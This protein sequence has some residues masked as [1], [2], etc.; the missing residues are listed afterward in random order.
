MK[1]TPATVSNPP[2]NIEFVRT[3]HIDAAWHVDGADA[4]AVYDALSM[5][6]PDGERFFIE[7]VKHYRAR[8][9]GKLASDVRDFI[10][11]E[12][13]HTREHA[14][15]N[16][17]AGMS[18]ELSARVSA[19]IQ[20][21]IADA[22]A[23]GPAAML[24]ATISLEHMTAVFADCVLRDPSLMHSRRDEVTRLWVWHA[25]EEAEHKGVAFDLFQCVGEKWG[26][27]K[28][29]QARVVSMVL[30][31]H[32]FLSNWARVSLWLMEARGVTGWD[33]R[34]RILK[35]WFGRRG[36]VRR[37]IGGYLSWFRPG[38]HPW[39]HDNHALI[40]KWRGAFPTAAA[41]ESPVDAAEAA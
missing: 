41:P 16:A 5:L 29:Y 27:W 22:R 12:A 3:A 39:D 9:T 18:P 19:L 38:F 20:A 2:R 23:Q 28:R 37:S 13:L 25:M 32:M 17:L 11:Q 7:S 34:K 14:A 31:T 8:A 40:E 26:R 15:F 36:L 10:A 1:S 6:F 33:A 35:V 24:A 30:A 21:R 4:S